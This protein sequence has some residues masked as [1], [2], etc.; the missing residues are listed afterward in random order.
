[1]PAASASA[2]ASA[3]AP[4][5]TAGFW[6]QF[7]AFGRPEGAEQLRT[8]LA[9]AF[10]GMAPRLS[11]FADGGLHRLQAGPFPSREAAVQAASALQVPGGA[12]PVV[13]ERR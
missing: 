7:G 8:R 11:V 6:L 3:S 12:T 13:V 4:S 10:Q 2:S 1:M 9:P 5:S